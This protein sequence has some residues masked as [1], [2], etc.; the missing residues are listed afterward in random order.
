MI[1]SLESLHRAAQERG[2][3][4]LAVA[5]AQ[6]PEV[7]LAVDA[8]RKL[9]IAT[10]ILVGDEDQIRTIA[11]AHNIP[12]EPH[13]ILPEPDKIQACRTAVKLVRDGQADAVMKGIVDTSIILKAVLDRD[14]GLRDAPVLSHVALFQV[15]GYDRLLYV[16]DAA[17]NIAPDVEAKKHIVSNAVKVAHALG[18]PNPIVACLC[19]VEKVNPK[20]PAT[21]DAA[22]L[23]NAI[24]P[25]AARHKGIEDPHAGHADIL[26]VPN[27][28][29]GNVFYKS[30]VFMA[31][32]QNA[33][34]IVGAKAPVIVTSRADSEQ[35]KLNSIALALT[36]ASN[37]L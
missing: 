26:L 6:D 1:Q 33:G 19:A 23:D 22:A 18:N 10:A 35:T 5:A 37:N 20:M 28:E 2:S 17:M 25:E 11:Q 30:M 3:R 16:T 14:I 21:L 12:L 15:P 13:R 34:L 36:V 24:S 32:S 7:L 29:T 8:A 4:V 9:G 27:I 31:K